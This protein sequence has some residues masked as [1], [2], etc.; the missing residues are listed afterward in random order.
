MA[1]TKTINEI[2]M[3]KYECNRVTVY[4]ALKGMT[5]SWRARCIREDYERII[6]ATA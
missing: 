2:L 1:K 3:E 5:H 6:K 4:R